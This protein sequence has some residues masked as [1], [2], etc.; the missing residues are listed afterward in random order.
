VRELI[1]WAQV[2]DDERGHEEHR[3]GNE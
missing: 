2:A 3:G 1:L